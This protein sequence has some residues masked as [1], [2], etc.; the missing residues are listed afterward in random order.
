MPRKTKCLRGFRR[1]FFNGSCVAKNSVRRLTKCPKGYRQCADKNCY[2][3]NIGLADIV[4]I[5]RTDNQTINAAEHAIEAAEQS[6]QAAEHSIEAN[7]HAIDVAEN[8]IRDSH[9]SP[10]PP[11]AAVNAAEQTIRSAEQ[12]IRAEEGAIQAEVRAIRA[13]E[14]IIHEAERSKRNITR[15][16]RSHGID[17][18]N[19]LSTKRVRKPVKHFY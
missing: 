2:S 17:Q 1:C 10:S 19:V 6:I 16:R 13:A 7:N 11:I 3:K 5:L 4:N 15:R 9:N 18:S 8:V 14:N 12:A